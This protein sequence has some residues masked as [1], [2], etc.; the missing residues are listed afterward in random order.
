MYNS[1]LNENIFLNKE[2]L[3]S[4]S[5]SINIIKVDEKSS[6]IQ[7]IHHTLHKYLLKHP[8]KLIP[9]PNYKITNIYLTY[10]LLYT[11]ESGPYHDGDILLYYL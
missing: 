6:I 4:I 8:E 2:I 1:K 11:F 10:L 9:D 3:L 5:I 7:L